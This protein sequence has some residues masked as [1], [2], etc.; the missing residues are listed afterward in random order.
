[1]KIPIY[2]VDAFAAGVFEGNP[3]AVCPLE[4]WIDDQILQQIAEENNLSE[5]AFFVHEPDGS[6]H[7][8]WFTPVHEVDLC[9]HATLA[10]AHVLFACLGYSEEVIRFNTR[11]GELT[12]TRTSAGYDMEFPSDY[13]RAAAVEG[14]GEILGASPLAVMEGVSDLLV[15]V[16]DE[17]TVRQLDPD[18]R[19]MAELPYRGCI[20]TAPGS[21][22][23]IVSRCFYPAYGI[24]EDPV[25]GS[26]HTTL[27]SYWSRKWER[28]ELTAAQLSKRGGFIR[29][30][31]L[32]DRVILSGQAVVYLTGEINI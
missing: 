27:F 29:G 10:T 32:K 20:V 25:T 15:E 5:T 4:G 14:I 3:A 18:F 16:K 19:K 9:G 26:A 7:L 24:D 21:E 12:V 28:D 1:M 31:V 23:D 17:T 22:T 30:R 11:S 6:F 2:Q 13:P 8:R